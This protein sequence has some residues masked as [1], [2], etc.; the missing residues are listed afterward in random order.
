MCSPLWAPKLPSAPLDHLLLLYGFQIPWLTVSLL[1]WEVVYNSKSI[2]P[3][4]SRHHCCTDK[5]HSASGTHKLS[6]VSSPSHVWE[7]ARLC[8]KHLVLETPFSSKQG[9]LF[10]IGWTFRRIR[11]GEAVVYTAKVSA[12]SIQI[13]TDLPFL[14]TWMYASSCLSNPVPNQLI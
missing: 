5:Q 7:M 2:L 13:F 9:C 8:A 1:A 14:W 11:R 10:R 12:S 6:N 3:A 4:S